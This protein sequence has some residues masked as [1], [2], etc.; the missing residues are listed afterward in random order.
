MP[1]HSVVSVL[2]RLGASGQI[3]RLNKLRIERSL[4][5]EGR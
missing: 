3:M 5:N 2:L 1:E 4:V